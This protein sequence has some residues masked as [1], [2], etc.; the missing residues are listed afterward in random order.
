[1]LFLDEIKMLKPEDEL[2]DELISEMLENEIFAYPVVD[3][4]DKI[5]G[6]LSVFDILK[7]LKN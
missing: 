2:T 1:M 7:K 5:V 3:S 4:D 6:T